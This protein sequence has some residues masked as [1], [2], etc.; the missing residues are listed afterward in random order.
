MTERRCI[1]SGERASPDH[2]V[3]LALSPEGEV[4]PDVRAKA[5]GRGAWIGVSRE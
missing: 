5:P 1:L 2:L 4:M 3:R